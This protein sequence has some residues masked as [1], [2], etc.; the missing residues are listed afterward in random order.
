MNGRCS[1]CT[2]KTFGLF[3]P[4]FVN[5]PELL[6]SIDDCKSDNLKWVETTQTFIQCVVVVQA[7]HALEEQNCPIENVGRQLGVFRLQ[8]HKT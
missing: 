4:V 3:Q 1:V 2:T 6:T 7:C 8:L 5:L